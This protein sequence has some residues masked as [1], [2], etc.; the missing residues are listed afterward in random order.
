MRKF[1]LPSLLMLTV[2]ALLPMICF[3][4]NLSDVAFAHDG[5]TQEE[6]DE[7]KKKVEKLTEENEKLS[8]VLKPS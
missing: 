4:V 5:P 3:F 2:L 6:F 8:G 1:L 7:L